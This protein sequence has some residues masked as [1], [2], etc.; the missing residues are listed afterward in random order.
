METIEGVYGPTMQK[1]TQVTLR[2]Q[3]GDVL[4]DARRVFLMVE[5]RKKLYSSLMA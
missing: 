5:Q 4:E 3:D 2:W 1:S